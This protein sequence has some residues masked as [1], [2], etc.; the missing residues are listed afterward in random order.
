MGYDSAA[1]ITITIPGARPVTIE[2]RPRQTYKLERQERSVTARP[3]V[4]EG[5]R[6][7]A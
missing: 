2:G 1:K 3:S 4:R 5:D 7:C 6:A